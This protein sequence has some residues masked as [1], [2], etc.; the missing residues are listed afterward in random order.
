MLFMIL[1]F[2]KWYIKYKYDHKS[3]KTVNK[4]EDPKVSLQD[5][6]ANMREDSS[7]Q[8]IHNQWQQERVDSS[9]IDIGE[10]T[11]S[12]LSFKPYEMA[13]SAFPME[14]IKE[15][16]SGRETNESF[17]INIDFSIEPV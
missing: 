15:E 16:E 12:I 6:N 9:V 13:S 4:Y 7:P 3:A 1:K 11:R 14:I 10:S 17:I 5:T 2:L 8:E